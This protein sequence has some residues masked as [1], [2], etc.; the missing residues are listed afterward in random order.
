MAKRI[1]RRIFLRGLGG[2]CV[3]APFLGSIAE[4]TVKAEPAAP[5]RRLRIPG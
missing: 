1:N 2:A 3:A 5:P 4:R